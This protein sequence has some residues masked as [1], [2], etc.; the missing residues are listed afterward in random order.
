MK[1]NRIRPIAICLFRNGDRILA[2]EGFDSVKQTHFH[3]PLGGGV[4]F[5][6]HSRDAIA[7]EIKEELGA[8]IED[9]RLL[10]MI[11]NLFTLEGR[12]GHEIVFVYDAKFT[13]RSLYE[14]ETLTG[15]EEWAGSFTATWVSL[16]EIQDNHVRLVPEKL[17]ELIRAM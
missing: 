13:D 7:R 12:Q 16:E 1:E 6:E 10:G 4:E 17:I 11:E 15:Y 9:T 3:R 5:G 2:A 14:R 8:E